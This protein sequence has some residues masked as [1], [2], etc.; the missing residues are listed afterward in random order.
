[1]YDTYRGKK[2]YRG[3]LTLLTETRGRRVTRDGIGRY[4]FG[5]HWWT[6]VVV[7]AKFSDCWGYFNHDLK[8]IFLCG[9]SQSADLLNTIIHEI[10]H[11]LD[12]K[13]SE[14]DVLRHGD[15]TATI[16][17]AFGCKV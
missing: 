15:V 5:R 1:M 10:G 2:R 4:K 6:I 16:L 8:T 7:D 12:P 11:G 14:K 9:A 13:R 3:F 17:T